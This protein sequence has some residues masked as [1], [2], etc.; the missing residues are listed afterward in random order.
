M[1]V[2]SYYSNDQQFGFGGWRRDD[3]PIPTEL[4]RPDFYHRRGQIGNY[5]AYPEVQHGDI[6]SLKDYDNDD[7][8]TGSDVINALIKA[9]CY[10]IREADVDGFRVDAVKHMGTVACSR[11]CSNVREYAQSLG[12]RHFFLFGEV[13]TPSDDIY[14]GYLGP[15]TSVD[16]PG[17]TVFFGLDSVLDFRLAEGVYGDDVN[18]SPYSSQNYAKPM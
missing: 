3:R 11:F 8:G 14:N 4:R 10:W 2:R 7:D 16:D 5:D 13:A 9:H 18:N 1:A 6:S 15:N 12:K 17:G